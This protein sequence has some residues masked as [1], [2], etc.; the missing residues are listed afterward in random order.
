MGMMNGGRYSL[1]GCVLPML[2]ASAEVK[3]LLEI[4]LFDSEEGRAAT[5]VM[6]F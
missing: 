2:R 5:M 3:T 4:G 6:S 1:A